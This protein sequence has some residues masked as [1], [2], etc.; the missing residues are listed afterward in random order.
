[1]AGDVGSVG[2]GVRVNVGLPCGD[3]G[4]RNEIDGDK[5]RFCDRTTFCTK[6]RRMMV[7]VTLRQSGR[8]TCVCV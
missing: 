5:D 1:M 3:I 4:F 2:S 8:R 7:V 6:G